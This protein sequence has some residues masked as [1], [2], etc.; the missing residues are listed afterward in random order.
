MEPCI[1]VNIIKNLFE[2]ITTIVIGIATI[3]VDQIEISF[4]DFLQDLIRCTGV[5]KRKTTGRINK[6]SNKIYN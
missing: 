5:K 3:V 4:I 6:N 2:K 1:N